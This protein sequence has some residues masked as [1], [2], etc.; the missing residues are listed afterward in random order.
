MNNQKERSQERRPPKRDSRLLFIMD[1]VLKYAVENGMIDMTYIREQIEMNKRKELLEKHPYKI[2]E[3]K[4]G[5]WYTYLPDDEKGR[6]LLKRNSQKSIEDIVIAQIKE[7][8]INPTIAD[9]FE[10]WNSRRL[11]LKKICKATY[12]RD[13]TCFKKYYSEFGNKKIKTVKKD[14]I[15]D[16]LE[17]KIAEF[18]L[19]AKAFSGL[20]S[21]TK[22]FLKFAK[23]K[24]YIQF[25]VE[26]SLDD[27]DLTEV[28]FRRTVKDDSDEVFS[29]PETDK[30]IEYL[31]KNLDIWNTGLLL[32]FVTGVRVGELSTLKHEDFTV[33]SVKIRRT[34]T[35]YYDENGKKIYE[36]KDFP[37]TKAGIRE[38]IIPADYRWILDRIKLFNPWGEYVF[39]NKSGKRMTNNCF[40]NR[41]YRI[42]DKLRIK[43]RST[44]K[45]RKTYGSILL[46]NNVDNRLIINQMGHT[47]I[48]TTET[49]YHRDRRTRDKKSSII[50]N[51]PDFK[52]NHA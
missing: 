4:D 41:L 10:E 26:E 48:V 35:S 14:E 45:I 7:D 32:M 36:V 23:K 21:I 27:M 42:C 50:S 24:G 34:E 19:S 17:E 43:R 44:H 52:I 2:W 47:D 40:R 9:V 29:E 11:E 5:K 33:D 8:E 28:S 20:L 30:I 3:G 25:S 38:V 51:I 12:D 13:V 39:V 37:K 22:R 6:R 46:D 1:D 31:K 16:F 49:K 18:D 15:V